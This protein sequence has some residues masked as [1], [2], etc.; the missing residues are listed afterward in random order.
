[1]LDCILDGGT[2]QV[3][4]AHLVQGSYNF[5]PVS[6]FVVQGFAPFVAPMHGGGGFV[7]H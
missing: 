5:L 7:L 1:M 4:F 6:G 3:V 2:M